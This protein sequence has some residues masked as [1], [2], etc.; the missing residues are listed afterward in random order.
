M[1]PLRGVIVGIV[2]GISHAWNPSIRVPHIYR[3][4]LFP[5]NM[6]L[7]TQTPSVGIGSLKGKADRNALFRATP[8]TDYLR[9]MTVL[10]RVLQG[11]A[12]YC[13]YTW[14]ATTNALIPQ[15]LT[16]TDAFLHWLR[17]E[18]TPWLITLAA[19]SFPSA[20]VGRFDALAAWVVVELVFIAICVSN[21]EQINMIQERDRDHLFQQH[22]HSSSAV[23]RSSSRFFKLWQ[24]CFATLSDGKAWLR[25]T[26]L[27]CVSCAQAQFV[28]SLLRC[29]ESAS[30]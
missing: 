20:L 3:R 26:C 12:S 14:R 21:Y 7:S 17:L 1:S 15:T 8:D 19:I 5:L 30:C 25:G 22:S 18:A 6:A 29:H 16:S 11:S 9:I 28:R 13:S 27:D 10:K 24:Q 23:L 2:V 4:S